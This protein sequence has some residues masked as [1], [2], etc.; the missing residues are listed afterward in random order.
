M[1]GKNKSY[2]YDDGVVAN[3]PDPKWGSNQPDANEESCV[4]VKFSLTST[5]LA[6]YDFHCT[7]EFQCLCEF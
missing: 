5:E 2:T 4:Y 3:V 1:T 6:L 7:S